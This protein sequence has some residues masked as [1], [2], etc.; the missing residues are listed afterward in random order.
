MSVDL[1]RA[2]H[3]GPHCELGQTASSVVEESGVIILLV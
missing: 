1:H 3:L 2:R